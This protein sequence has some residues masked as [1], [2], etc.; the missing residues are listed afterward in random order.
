MKN[1]SYFLILCLFCGCEERKYS[2]FKQTRIA[3]KENTRKDNK[4]DNSTEIYYLAKQFDK[5]WKTKNEP[6][7]S[8]AYGVPCKA[9]FTI[10]EKTDKYTT[11]TSEVV[12]VGSFTVEKVE[13]TYYEP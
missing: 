8:Y 7:Y 3:D 9:E 12:V 5:T 1:I 11:K 10:Q 6:R 4:P 2:Q 13:V